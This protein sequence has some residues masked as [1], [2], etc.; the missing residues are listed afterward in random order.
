MHNVLDLAVRVFDLLLADVVQHD[1]HSIG[2]SYLAAARRDETEH[3]QTVDNLNG[4]HLKMRLVHILT[5]VANKPAPGVQLVAGDVTAQNPAPRRLF[6]LLPTEVFL[7]CHCDTTDRF[8]IHAQDALQN[9][10][11]SAVGTLHFM[12]N[13]HDLGAYLQ[14]Q[15]ADTPPGG[16]RGPR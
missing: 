5:A 10:G 7:D 9:I 8:G 12:D 3:A 6:A 16:A 2:G 15:M 11:T 14:V 1:L 4:K 13:P